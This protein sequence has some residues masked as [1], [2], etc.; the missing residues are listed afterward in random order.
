MLCVSKKYPCGLTLPLGHILVGM[1]S[2][3]QRAEAPTHSSDD[4]GKPGL[5]GA[6]SV[7]FQTAETDGRCRG[8]WKLRRC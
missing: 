8:P 6:A 4:N 1:N 3:S 5:A 7:R 2:I